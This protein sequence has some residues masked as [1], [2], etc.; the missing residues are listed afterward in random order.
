MSWRRL[1]VA[2]AAVAGIAVTVSLGFWQWGRAHEKIAL[3]EARE[4]VGAL[5]ALDA[6]AF[7]QPQ[8]LPALVHRAVAVE[9][10]WVADRT[11]F[12]ENR[13]MGGS[14]GFYVVTPLR[15]AGS[16]AVVLVQ[17]GWAPRDFQ[18]REHLPPVTTLPGRVQVRGHL[19]P[20]PAKLYDFAGGERGPIRQNLDLDAFRAETGLPLVP[21]SIQQEGPDSEGLAR[22]WPLPASGAD[23]NYGYAAQWWSFGAL[24][25]ILY[26]WFQFIAPRRRA[27]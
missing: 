13:Q 22:H 7:A 18:R 1:V 17:R 26:V 15:I 10:E 16:S 21:V 25:A 12:L 2:L 23:R 8:A 6:G 24:I 11:V 20:P 14:V 5:P 3:Q 9:G 4:R 19:A 27:P